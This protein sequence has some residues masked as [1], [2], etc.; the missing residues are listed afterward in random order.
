[1]M[2]VKFISHF[3]KLKDYYLFISGIRNSKKLSITD[4]KLNLIEEFEFENINVWGVNFHLDKV[5]NSCLI[6]VT[7]TETYPL[8]SKS[9]QGYSTHW[10]QLIFENGLFK[11]DLIETW[12]KSDLRVVKSYCQNGT[13]Y[14]VGLRQL[15]FIYQ[16]GNTGESTV[17]CYEKTNEHL[18]IPIFKKAI[19]TSKTIGAKFDFI[20]NS[21]NIFLVGICNYG[22]DRVIILKL[23]ETGDTVLINELNI[24]LKKLHHFEGAKIIE[25][26][27]VAFAYFWTTC[28]EQTSKYQFEIYK[29]GNIL[30]NFL[31]KTINKAIDKDNVINFIW[32]GS[33]SLSISELNNKKSSIYEIE[34]DGKFIKK[35]TLENLENLETLAFGFEN[36]ILCVNFDKKIEVIK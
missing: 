14:W 8:E 15:N 24:P 5:S 4:R 26:E 23:S 33:Q 32:N 27:N 17:I 9:Y 13:R 2:D 31:D 34:V 1:M 25:K 22:Q 36:D 3:E 35:A 20:V 29:T 21:N 19:F 6:T 11:F 16:T 7:T 18:S 10:F 30:D 28:T 12:T